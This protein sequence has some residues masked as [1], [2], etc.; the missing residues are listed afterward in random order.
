MPALP[1]TAMHMT[2]D[3]RIITIL[4]GPEGQQKSFNVHQPL[5][6][7]W[8]ENFVNALKADRWVEVVEGIIRFPD[9]DPE[10]F[11]LYLSFAYNA[12]GVRSYTED[13]IEADVPSDRAAF[14]ELFD[15]QAT[16][17]AKVFVLAHMLLDE[18]MVMDVHEQIVELRDAKFF[19]DGKEQQA[20]FPV[21]GISA[22]YEGLPDPDD[23]MFDPRAGLV[24]GYNTWGGSLDHEESKSTSQ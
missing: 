14:H 19:F 4:V 16:K 22:L 3:S 24:A 23:V 1:Y 10:I 17:L 2:V 6:E 13:I 5:L 15:P 7:A 9:E 8:S 18:D 21:E 12:N 11:H 20:A